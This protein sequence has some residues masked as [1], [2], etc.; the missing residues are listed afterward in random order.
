LKLNDILVVIRGGGDLATG[1][2]VRLFRAGFPVMILEI[3]RPTVIRLP[4]SFARAIYEG[5]VIVEDVEAVLIP[6]W[7][8]AEEIIK[9]GKIPVL[10]DPKGNCIEKL[11][12]IVIVDAILAKHNL[13]T[14][15]DQAPLVIA[16]GP[17]FTAGE[18]VDVVIETKRGHNLGKVYYQ[19]QAVPDTGVPGEVGGESKR[20]L[21]R[22]PAEGKI[23]PLHQIG[24]LVKAGEII[25]EV[26][27][28]PSKAEISGVLR[29][30]IYP[31]SW[32]T[33]RMKVGD[34][35]PRGVREYCF[36]VSD[37]ARSLGGAVLEAICAY[38]NKK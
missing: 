8:K 10:I 29:G 14:R 16:L 11:S 2:A 30:L 17:G 23:M 15:M 38:L 34:I 20:R 33:R 1:V 35:D 7:E 24:D 19:G 13:G 31:Q 37:K 26:E 9:K 12:P 3:E 27:G 28:V 25:A 18:D 32:V 22:A 21:L 36:T 5:K 6:S 4:V